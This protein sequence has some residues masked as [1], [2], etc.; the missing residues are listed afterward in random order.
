MI[1]KKI[2]TGLF[3]LTLLNSCAQN[4]AVLGPAYTLASTGNIYQAGFTFGTDRAITQLTGKS[5]SENVKQLLTSNEQDQDTEFFRLVKNNIE[6]TRK[7]LNLT[8]P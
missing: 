7:K 1:V 2:I 4:I 8:N 6:Q 5:T 3:L